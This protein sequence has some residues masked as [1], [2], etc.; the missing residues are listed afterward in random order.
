MKKILSVALSTAMAFSMFA[1]VAFGDD[2]LNT[3]QKFDVLK[4]K[5]IFTGYPDG[6]A[7]LDKE[8]TRAE[9][10]KVLVGIMGLEPIEGK[11]SFKDKN[12]KADKWPAPYVEAVYAAGLMEG[13]NTT[14]MIFDFNGKITIQEMAKVLVT[15]QKLEIPTETDNNASDWA[16]GYVQAAINA[17]LVDAK[18]NP[19]A[20]ASRSQLVDVA[21][22]IY[23]AQQKP[24]VVSYEVKEDGK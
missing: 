4:E 1:S 5:G 18:A 10:A 15:A 3:Q 7:G 2:A 6:T 23:L 19:K 24:A 17:G 22:S 14:K 16:K 20:N 13:K 8:M 12:Y 11:A 9:F 21:Y